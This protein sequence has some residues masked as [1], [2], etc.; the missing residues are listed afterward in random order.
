MNLELSDDLYLRFRDLLLMRCGLYYPERKRGDL[1]YGLNMALASSGRRNLTELYADAV[2]GG[3]GWEAILAHLTVGETYFF[4]NGAQFDVLRDHIVP[5]LRE[6]RATLRMLRLWSAGCA[7]GEEP[8]SLAILLNDLLYNGAPW[9]ISILATDINPVFLERAREALYGS[10]SFRETP[11][12]LRDRFWVEEHGRWRLL[13]EIRR[14]VN[15]ARLNLAD[16]FAYALA[17]SLDAPLLY[18]GDDFAKTD[19]RSVL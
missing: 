15:F 14:M 19:I 2:A 6:R 5:E 3:P 17:K 8:Y 10:W 18:K 13:P 11:N 16:C 7:T 1:A 12:D 4:R 9:S